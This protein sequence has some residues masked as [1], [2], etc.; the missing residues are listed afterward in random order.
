MYRSPIRL[1]L[2]LVACLAAAGHAAPTRKAEAPAPNASARPIA[3]DKAPEARP[4]Y[5]LES[6]SKQLTEMGLTNNIDDAYV[7]CTVKRGEEENQVFFYVDESALWIGCNLVDSI[8]NIDKVP[9]TAFW[10]LLVENSQNPPTH[11]SLDPKKHTLYLYRPLSK[12]VVPAADL[13]KV[14]ADFDATVGRT[15]P[16]YGP[17]IFTPGE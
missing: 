11:F 5:T 2:L 16:L 7:Y 3:D 14:I 15:K 9:A 10:K 6:V 4:T 13:N 17:D 1:A 8:K 12:H